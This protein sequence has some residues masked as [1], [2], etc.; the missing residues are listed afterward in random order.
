VK[1]MTLFSDR[2]GA[3]ALELGLVF[4]A[5]VAFIIGIAQ[6][7][8]LLWIDNLLHY[9]V[10]AAA[11]CGAVAS[12][13][14]PCPNPDDRSTTAMSTAAKNLFTMAMPI[15]S[16]P[17]GTFAA[18]TSCA[19]SGLLGSYTVHVLLVI[20]VNVTAKSCFPNY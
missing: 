6:V 3:A 10:E 7:A 8:Y 15:N 17:N 4:P 19:G 5:F 2:G 9:S 14:Y 11:R 1:V 12:T 13:T 20:P 18:N 16:I